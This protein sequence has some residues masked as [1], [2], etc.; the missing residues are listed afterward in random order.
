M[1]LISQFK[2]VPEAFISG[3]AKEKYAEFYAEM[4]AEWY[5]TGGA[6]ENP[7]VQALAKEMGWKI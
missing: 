3:Y 1:R 7:L 2:D 6:T 5:L 4:F